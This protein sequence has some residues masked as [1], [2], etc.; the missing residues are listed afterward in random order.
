M[1]P[2]SS[3]GSFHTFFHVIPHRS[4][5]SK[6]LRSLLVHL[7]AISRVF[8][9]WLRD[10]S[11]S[12]LCDLE[13]AMLFYTYH[14]C[15]AMLCI[16]AAYAVLQCLS[17]TFVDRVK[18]NKRIFKIFSPLCRQA[19]LVFPYQTSW[20]YSDGKLPPLTGTSNAT[21]YEK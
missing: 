2:F 20:H 16:S 5:S 19:I 7:A 18:T 10:L 9:L 4:S 3:A 21:G 6:H 1:F 11:G 17:V 12:W 13:S 8:G 14:F 15:R